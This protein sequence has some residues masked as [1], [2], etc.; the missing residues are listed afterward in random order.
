MCC[1]LSSSQ[2]PKSSCEITGG[3]SFMPNFILIRHKIT[4]ICTFKFHQIP[5]FCRYELRRAGPEGK[6]Q[7]RQYRLECSKY[8]KLLA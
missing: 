8:G 7:T 1:L 4:Q 2:F 5:G 3:V 6:L